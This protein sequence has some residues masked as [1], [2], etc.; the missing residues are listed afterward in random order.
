MALFDIDGLVAGTARPVQS[1]IYGPHPAQACDL[2]LPGVAASGEGRVAV[3]VHGGFW[4]ARYD[5]SLSGMLV[6]DLLGHGWA[7]WNVDYRAVGV[8]PSAGGGWPGTYEDVAAAA[9]LLADAADE[10]ALPL[11]RVVVVGHS[12][13]GALAL[14]LAGRHRLPAGAPGG[15]PRLRPAAVVAQAAVCD[16]VV[17]AHD[18]LGDGAVLDL[19]AGASPSDNPLAYGVAN[20]TA[21]LPLGVPT[22]VVTGDADDA[23]PHTES[24]R[25]ADAARGG[26]G[27]CHPAR[28]AGRRPLRPPAADD[29]GLARDPAVDAG[30]SAVTLSPASPRRARPV[31]DLLLDLVRTDTAGGGESAAAQRCAA[32]LDEAGLV[33]QHLDWE[34]GRSQVVARGG[35]DA[36]V[37][38]TGHLDT[39]PASAGTASRWTVDPWVGARDGN[40][41]VG[42]GTSDMK[43]GVAAV[44][45]AVV[46][47]ARRPHRC[48]GVQV[49]LTAG[50]ETG[51][52][53][54]RQI[55]AAA[56][57]RGGPL[58]VAE[59]TGNRMLLGH[60]G[61]L[62]LRLTAAGRA[63]H[64]SAP[65]LGDNAVVRLAR[66][67]VA[68]HDETGWPDDEAFGPVTANV[69]Y[70]AGGVQP[71]V[72]PDAAELLLDVRVVPGVRLADVRARVAT[73]AG[74]GVR[75]EDH[76][77]LAPVATPGDDPFVGLVA[78]ALTDAGLD[79][80][81][82][83]PARYFTDASVLA[84]L[85]GPVG[86]PDGDQV[87]TVVLGPGEVDQCHVADEWCDVTKVEAAVDVYAALLDRW[88]TDGRAG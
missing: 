70:L 7:V 83:L 3:L 44:V 36:P 38:F 68:L 56:L 79:P 84:G 19:M 31:L 51:C 1:Y 64:G 73:L 37:T 35:G 53:G 54:A 81:P 57:T 16:L 13:G 60:K 52:T 30:S 43:S 39:V 78:G 20:P 14:W 28:G 5:R 42:R 71:N 59:P 86:E 11:D 82:G 74:D 41:L 66:A 18:R 63:A 22:L 32:D 17:A 12:A 62:W 29:P 49:V 10:H 61:A 21:L 15:P 26:R 65:W 40:R 46:E 45:V 80:A 6:D 2:Y 88:C 34:L 48:R 75:V 67:A 72:V 24:L 58:V 4:R 76:V 8:G 33:V 77:V 25:Y 85:L 9:D 23:V 27:R 87:P 47:H 55:T 50:E 69:G